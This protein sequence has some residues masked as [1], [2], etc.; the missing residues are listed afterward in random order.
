MQPNVPNQFGLVLTCETCEKDLNLNE[1]GYFKL[2]KESC[3]SGKISLSIK[4]AVQRLQECHSK[5]SKKC[6]GSK[7]I[8]RNV[9]NNFLVMM[10]PK[11]IKEFEERISIGSTELHYAGQVNYSTGVL[12]NKY[13]YS[14]NK[15][16]LQTQCLYF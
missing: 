7:V 5:M 15:Y 3:L 8:I 12:S 1:D 13:L 9:S 14:K 16:T 4:E 2:A 11:S 10:E 6:I